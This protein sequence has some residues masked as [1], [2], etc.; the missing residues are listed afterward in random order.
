MGEVG[1]YTALSGIEAETTAMDAT[2][3]N[4][5]NANTAGF[6]R[7]QA[8]FS[9]VPTGGVLVAGIQQVTSQLQQA[10]ALS[11]TS[12]S[13]AA[14]AFQN[15]L[16]TAQ[17]AFPEPGADG[18]QSQ[19]SSFWSSWDDVANDPS[20]LASRTQVVNFATNMVSGLNQASSNLSQLQQSSASQVSS[21]TAE[22]N[23]LLSQIA[24]L[25]KS[26]VAAGSNGAANGLVD[27][28]NALLSSLAGDIGITVRPQSDGSVNVYAGG[29]ALV[30]GATADSLSVSSSGGTVSVTS[31]HTGT[32]V[33]ITQGTIGGLLQGINQSIPTYQARLDQVASALATTVNTQLAAGQTAAGA[34]GQPLF[35]AIGGGAVTAASISVNPP[36]AADPTLLAAASAGAGPLDGSNAQAMA[37]LASSATGPDQSY[38]IMIGD[39]G[40]DVQ[41]ATS[42]ASTQAVFSQQASAADQAVSGVNTDEEMVNMLR[43]QHGYEAAAK[44][45]TTLSSTLESLL[46]A[47]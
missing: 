45:I 28:R 7:E 41:A 15:L 3:N 46:A 25:N 10:N 17:S 5:A 13:S 35:V 14:S 8:Q 39:L 37:E 27:Q 36:V 32:A 12:S 23:N 9:A 2:S 40:S 22:V 42:L 30:Q 44:V 6:V 43:Y 1:L 33:P 38:R 20:Q 11:A 16:S 29:L 47:V 26:A 21:V 34:P 31:A 19:L 4:V 24:A 18:L